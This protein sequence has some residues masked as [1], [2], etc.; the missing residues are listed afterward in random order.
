M[1]LANPAF[2]A[3]LAILIPVLIAFLVKKQKRVVKVPSTLLW[4]LGA[5]SISKSRKIRNIRRLVALLA[6]LAAVGAF[7][8]AA[9]RPGG[10]RATST[11]YIVDISASMAGGPIDDARAY[12][13]REIAGVGPNGRIAIIT[14]GAEP[15]VIVPPSPPGPLVER[16]VARI[17]AERET[18]NLDEALALAEGMHSH[19][20]LLTDHAIDKSI[21]RGGWTEERVFTRGKVKDNVGIVSMYTRTAPDARDDEER[22]ATITIATSSTNGRRARLV[23]KFNGR[24]VTDKGVDIPNTGETTENI[25]IRGAGE[26]VAKVTPDD[27][28][29]DALAIDDEASLWEVARK[30]PHVAVIYPKEAKQAAPFFVMRALEAAGVKDLDNLDQN[31]NPPK[32]ADVAVVFTDGIAV[33][34]DIPIV[35]VNYA[36]P[37]LGLQPSE[38]AKDK[39]HL[40]SLAA[41]DPLM[42]GVALDELTTNHAFTA[43]PPKG[44]RSLVD[45]DGGPV[46]IAGGAEKSSWVWIGI[47]PNQSDLVLRVAFPVLIGNLMTQLGGATQVITAK[48]TPR[49]ETRLEETDAQANALA[50]ATTPKWRIPL[51]PPALIAI[52]GALL[53]AFEGWLSLRRRAPETPKKT[54]P[55]AA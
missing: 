1:T 47:D 38:L 13:K 19:V 4:R 22:E 48:T 10:S 31:D 21:S 45:F 41:E 52:V 16:G 20:I 30:P 49:V 42:R 29:K 34:K 43:V 36:A 3:A 32:N 39:T 35:Y 18:G 25:T 23:V 27:G 15:H 6:C 50:S 46:V 26:L 2:L 40:R 28:K 53:L 55:K 7:A 5:K 24:I 51:S 54:A 14:A 8:L 44:T 33:P 37:E 9:A 12:L 11:V 17:E